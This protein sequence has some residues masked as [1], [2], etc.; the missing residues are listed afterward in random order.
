M[1]IFIVV[2]ILDVVLQPLSHLVW[3]YDFAWILKV[4]HNCPFLVGQLMANLP[5]RAIIFDHELA[6]IWPKKNIRLR[7]SNGKM[8]ERTCGEGG[9]AH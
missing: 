5:H 4:T 7:A 6:D 1:V 3:H 8:R 2:G 9:F